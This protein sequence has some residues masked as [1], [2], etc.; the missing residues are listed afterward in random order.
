MLHSVYG[1]CL[2]KRCRLVSTPFFAKE[3][4]RCGATALTAQEKS[5]SR[6][7]VRKRLRNEVQGDCG[8]EQKAHPRSVDSDIVPV[9]AMPNVARR[10]V[11]SVVWNAIQRPPD[12]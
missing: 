1:E 2:R 4:S 9:C 12:C 5:G 3:V 10:V 6:L 8:D 11:Q 7:E